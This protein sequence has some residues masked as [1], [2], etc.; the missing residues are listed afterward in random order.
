[1]KKIIIIFLLLIGIISFS[2]NINTGISVLT[3]KKSNVALNFGF[4]SKTFDFAFDMY[5]DFTTQVKLTTITDI[6]VLI[7]KINNN[8]NVEGGI[9]WFNDNPTGTKERSLPFIYAGFKYEESLFFGKLYF[10]YPLQENVSLDL[11]D[12]LIL[13]AGV[14]I[15]K[16]QN[17]I[18]DIKIEFRFTKDRKDFSIYISTPV[19]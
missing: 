9:I 15:P 17:F 16:P 1:M 2:I 4:N 13:K 3:D 8:I 14:T 12:Y 7:S 5:P 19:R 10:G 6:S 11:A 18:D